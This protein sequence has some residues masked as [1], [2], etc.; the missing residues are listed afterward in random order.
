MRLKAR[1]RGNQLTLSVNGVMLVRD[2]A[3]P[4]IPAAGP[5]VLKSPGDGKSLEFANVLVKRL[6]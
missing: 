6:D 2:R 3:V 5:W 1:Q 4:G